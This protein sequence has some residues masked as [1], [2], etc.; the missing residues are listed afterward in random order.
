MDPSNADFILNA[1]G[2]KAQPAYE[3]TAQRTERLN[4]NVLDTPEYKDKI[5]QLRNLYKAVTRG[6]ESA[7]GVYGRIE[8]TG[9]IRPAS[10]ARDYD[11]LNQ[12]GELKGKRPRLTREQWK[13]LT[14]D[15][16]RRY[17]RFYTKDKIITR[18]EIVNLPLGPA[19]AHNMPEMTPQKFGI[20]TTAVLEPQEIMKRIAADKKKFVG[21]ALST[22]ES[23]AVQAT[24]ILV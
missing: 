13:G 11:Q 14:K 3:G 9:I 18:G 15:E 7:T 4:T 5:E 10:K 6:R 19:Q 2:V 17:K 8:P 1:F 22:K 24:R 20:P 21:K 23:T 16:R 12:M